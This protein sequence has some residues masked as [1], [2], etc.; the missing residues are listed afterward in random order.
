MVGK[1]NVMWFLGLV[2]VKLSSSKPPPIPASSPPAAIAFAP[3]LVIVLSISLIAGV[4]T[5]ASSAWLTDYITVQE[6]L[7]RSPRPLTRQVRCGRWLA[8]VVHHPC[9]ASLRVVFLFWFSLAFN[10][11][12]SPHG[13]ASRYSHTGS[14]G[15]IRGPATLSIKSRGPL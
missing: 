11:P 2:G 8:T 7:T 9:M 1:I 4:H 10:R 12:K 5:G 13:G 6:N 3:A 15:D 14:P